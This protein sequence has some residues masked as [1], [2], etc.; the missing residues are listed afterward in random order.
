[1]FMSREQVLCGDWRDMNWDASK[2]FDSSSDPTAAVAVRD[3]DRA[4]LYTGAFVPSRA[5]GPIFGRLPSLGEL[6]EPA[7]F[8]RDE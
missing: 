8:Q 2:F 7:C 6:A 5:I 1:M 4:T 3:D